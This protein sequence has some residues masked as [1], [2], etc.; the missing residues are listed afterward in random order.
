PTLAPPAVSGTTVT[1]N[2]TPASGDPATSY[3]LEAGSASGRSDLAN[4][5]TGSTETALT[6]TDVPPGTYFVRIRARNAS[7]TSA[8]S[9]E[10]IVVVS[11]GCA[12]APAP[13]T[14]LAAIVNQSAVT[15]TWQAPASGCPASS[16]IIE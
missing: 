12:T 14:S 5:D 3:V 16:Y 9:N 7:G 8:P 6:A 10:I 1:V 4:A 15:L 2:W 11:G 13:P